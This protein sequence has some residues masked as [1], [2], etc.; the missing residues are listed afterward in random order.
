MVIGNLLSLLML[1]KINFKAPKADRFVGYLLDYDLK[2]TVEVAGCGEEGCLEEKVKSVAKFIATY[3]P[4]LPVIMNTN[5]RKRV[6]TSQILPSNFRLLGVD[7][8]KSLPKHIMKSFV[9]HG[10]SL[11][12]VALLHLLDKK[13]PKAQAE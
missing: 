3:P 5:L 12:N 1:L 8:M 11:L 6:F 9:L 13:F 2:S 4:T 10:R 7:S